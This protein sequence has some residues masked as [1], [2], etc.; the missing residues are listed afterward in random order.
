MVPATDGKQ[1][2]DSGTLAEGR[3]GSRL[4]PGE[5]LSMCSHPGLSG[6]VYLKK[7]GS[8]L[9]TGRR[10]P[11]WG[12]TGHLSTRVS[13]RTCGRIW[14]GFKEAGLSSG[15]DAVRKGSPVYDWVS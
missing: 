6:H 9:I 11:A 4:R 10:T 12:S 1:V 7:L 5:G 13:G 14:E 2:Y 15:V 3:H 8:L